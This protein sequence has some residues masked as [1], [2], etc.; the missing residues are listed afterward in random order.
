MTELCYSLPYGFWPVVSIQ[1]HILE[2]KSNLKRSLNHILPSPPPKMYIELSRMLAVWNYL[3]GGVFSDFIIDQSIVSTKYY[4]TK[5]YCLIL[6]ESLLKHHLKHCNHSIPHRI[7][8]YLNEVKHCVPSAHQ[9]QSLTFLL[10][11]SILLMI[12]KFTLIF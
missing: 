6:R 5:Y 10:K 9:E 8:L 12:L 7:L 2:M 1:A 4:K 3:F 11:K